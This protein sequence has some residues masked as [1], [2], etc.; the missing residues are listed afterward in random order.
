[1]GPWPSMTPARVLALQ[2]ERGG[3]DIERGEGEIS[4]ARTWL[5]LLSWLAAKL[6][7]LMPL[8]RGRLRSRVDVTNATKKRT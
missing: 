8:L 2:H 1:M 4:G 5:I 6:E 7:S 3:Y